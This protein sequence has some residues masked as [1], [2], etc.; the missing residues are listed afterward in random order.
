MNDEN[1][2]VF[3]HP[4]IKHKISL[5]RDK[6][7]GTNEFRKLVEEIAM[8]EGYEALSDLPTELVEVT[9]PIETCLTPMIAGR[10]LAIVPILRAGLG[11]VSGILALVPT[12]KVGHIGMYRDETTHEPVEYYCKLPSPIE[13]RTIVVTDPMLAT[14]GSAVD[15]I[16]Q[17]KK[18][19]GRT[20]KFMCI[21]AAPEGVKRLH[22]AHP[23]VQ[24][25][26][27]SLDREL[28]A[29][30]YICPGLGDAGDRIFGT[31]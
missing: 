30:A 17:I 20:I 1:I 16:D 29:D 12:A 31:K 14:G 6:A 4:L 28:N 22:E 15:A 2:K 3:D 21:I 27:G 13:E 23:D 9:T 26:I 18:H 11:M 5:L 7:T 8:L 19:G 10:K 25:Y 24:I